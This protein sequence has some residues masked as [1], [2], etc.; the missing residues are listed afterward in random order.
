VVG[1]AGLVGHEE[2]SAVV[3]RWGVRGL[4][5]A[6]CV[7]LSA[8]TLPVLA[9][10]GSVAPHLLLAPGL[11][12]SEHAALERNGAYGAHPV[13]LI[14]LGDSIAMTLG[15]G[16]GIDAQTDYGVTVSDDAVIGCDLDPQLQV[17]TSGAPGPATPG[18]GNWRTLWSRLM[19]DQRPSVVALGLG[20]WEVTDHLLN[21]RWVHVGEPAWDGHLTADLQS[22]ITILHSF[23]AKVVLFTMPYVDP[24]DRQP[25][26]QPWSENTPARVQAYNA[27]VRQVARTRPGV[28]SVID[29][30]RMLSPHGVYAASLSGVDV[31]STDGIH[32][33]V[34][35]GQLLQ[36][37]ILPA[38]DRIGM[39]DEAAKARA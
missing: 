34:D 5:V 39:E 15:M 35:G 12:T 11:S 19:A 26:G 3:R 8:T 16:L 13:H 28:V 9:A 25:N 27:L 36:R 17:I 18:C 29:L 32:I 23:G 14:V 7:L 1:P 21:G 10:A 20:R 6:T 33:S 24:S 4:V 31:R 30:N 38:V 2:D 22:A 37:Q